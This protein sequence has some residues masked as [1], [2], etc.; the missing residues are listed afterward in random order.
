METLLPNRTVSS[1]KMI[2]PSG[3]LFLL[4]PVGGRTSVQY[5]RY[6]AIASAKEKL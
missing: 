5:G 4:Q 6:L 1:D 3:D 2:A